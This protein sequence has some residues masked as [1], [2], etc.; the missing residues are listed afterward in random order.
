MARILVIDDSPEITDILV[1][2][3][4]TLG[5]EGF[6]GNDSREAAALA[7]KHKP[8]L[9]ILDYAMPLQD[10]VK[11]LAQVR[12]QGGAEALPVVFLSGVPFYQLSLKIDA[13]PLV[14]YMTKPVDFVKLSLILKELLEPS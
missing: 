14:R 9:L 1:S 10:G 6:S 5:H 11:T 3:L 7:V 12:A 2:Y 13:D 8:A 4:A